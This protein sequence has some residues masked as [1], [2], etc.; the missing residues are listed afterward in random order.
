MLE[1]YRRLYPDQVIDGVKDTE[2]DW[3]EKGLL[4]LVEDLQ[5]DFDVERRFYLTGFSA[6]GHLV[7][8][9]IFRHPDRLAGAAPMSANFFSSDY[10]SSKGKIAEADLRLPIRLFQGEDDRYR[11]FGY[12]GR[13]GIPPLPAYGLVLGLG[14]AAT[15]VLWLWTRKRKWPV[16]AALATLVVFGLLLHDRSLSLDAQANT[17]VA[18][19]ED[20]GYSNVTRTY[21]PGMGHDV[22]AQLVLDAFHLDR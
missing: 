15:G 9:M 21:V 6:G 20:F 5:R 14:I 19:L 7:Y 3:D 2:E 12:A 17:A 11:H 8:R 22:R 13:F 1:K 10:S 18:M 4:A 16:L